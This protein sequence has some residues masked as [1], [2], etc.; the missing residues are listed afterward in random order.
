MGFKDKFL[1]GFWNV[2]VVESSIDDVFNNPNNMK[3]RWVRHRYRDR[4]F[5]DPF[6]CDQDQKYYYVLVEEYIFYEDKGKISRL[7][8]D[9]KTMKL[10]HKE[11]ILNDNH[12]LSYPYI[13]DDYIIPEGYRS[14]AT[15][16]YKKING[17]ESYQRIKLIDNALIDPTLLKYDDRFWIFATTK[18][19]PKD[20]VSKLSIFHSDQFGAFNPHENNPVKI[21]IKSARPSGNF[22]EY[23]GKLYRPAMDCEKTYGH[24]I[25]IM[26]VKKLSAQDYEEQEVMVL[27]SKH[28]S[29]YNIGLH[30]FNVYENCIFVDGYGE[31]YS[32]LLK[33]CFVKLR[34][35]LQFIYDRHD[36]KGK[37]IIC[38]LEI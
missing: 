16:A 10:V 2:G 17:G 38:E 29:P 21:D 7:T 5:A 31:Y 30:T 33:P 1:L 32:Y 36:N 26:E 24:R 27:P 13:F 3:I 4:Y 37:E 14:G 15:Y 35:L 19:T 6:L 28:P 12:H 11:L 18:E 25:R 9:K 23:Q 20:A 34:K 8:I 22:F